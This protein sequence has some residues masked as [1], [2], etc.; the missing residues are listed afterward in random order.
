M[1]ALLADGSVVAAGEGDP[2]LAGVLAHPNQSGHNGFRSLGPHL[3]QAGREGDFTGPE[4]MAEAV[5]ALRQILVEL[6]VVEA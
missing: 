1:D 6:G 2:Q 5:D 4:L 3:A